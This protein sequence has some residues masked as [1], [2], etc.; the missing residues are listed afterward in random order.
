LPEDEVGAYWLTVVGETWEGWTMPA[1]LIAQSRYRDRITFVN[2]YVS[3]AEVTQC[4]AEA[5]AVVLPYHRAS[6]SGALHIA[7]SCGLPVVVT[8]VGGLV[9][10]VADYDGAILVPPNNPVRLRD[11]LLEVAK[12]QHIRFTDAHS[13]EHTASNYR[14]LFELL[15]GCSAFEDSKAQQDYTMLAD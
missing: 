12:L 5:D 14:I 4:F 13:W 3:D 1:N 6:T 15:C 8:S 11:A 2:R 7:M 9:E 10:A